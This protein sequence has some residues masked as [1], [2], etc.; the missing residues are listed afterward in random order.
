MTLLSPKLSAAAF[1]ALCIAACTVGPVGE[2]TQAQ[3]QNQADDDDDR[4][5]DCDDPDCLS[6]ARCREGA[7]AWS[8]AGAP[9]DAGRDAGRKPPLP[10]PDTGD[11]AV[12][13]G[14]DVDGG[15]P[16]IDASVIPCTTAGCGPGEQC[17]NGGCVPDTNVMGSTYLL[18]VDS[19]VVPLLG[20]FGTC[21]DACTV[22]ELVV[23]PCKPDPYVVVTLSRGGEI[24]T[25]GI[26]EW[27]GNTTE[28][29]WTTEPF[30]VE[31]RPGDELF[32]QAFDYDPNDQDPE[33]MRC[34]P[35]LGQVASGSL[36][37]GSSAGHIDASIT[38]LP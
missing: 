31:L 12:D 18:S 9:R 29:T 30:T 24:T 6:F 7:P 36:V 25:V 32:F 21:F 28:P 37:C 8:D 4:L 2:L 11:A 26:T 27:V 16:A 17:V 23:C 5:I 38:P 19:A 35:D 13:G 1:A 10:P 22:V 33:M 34:S 14:Y 15:A 20:S 3:C